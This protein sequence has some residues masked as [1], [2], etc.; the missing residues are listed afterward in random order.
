MRQRERFGRADSLRE[1]LVA[2]RR[3][4]RQRRGRKADAPLAAPMLDADRQL[5]GV[6][7]EDLRA[8]L[9]EYLLFGFGH[10]Q[11][12]EPGLGDETVRHRIH[13]AF[14]QR[15]EARFGDRPRTFAARILGDGQIRGHRS[16]Q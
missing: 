12:V 13:P 1:E 4:V 6:L 10:A 3:L 8:H 7:L 5:H 2:L 16:M 14:Q 15:Q 9:I 11:R